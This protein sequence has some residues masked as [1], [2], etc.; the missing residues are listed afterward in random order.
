[1]WASIDMKFFGKM[2]TGAEPLMRN[3]SLSGRLTTFASLA[4]L[5]AGVAVAVVACSSTE[6]RSG[7]EPEPKPEAGIEAGNPFTPGKVPCS[8]LACKRPT[9]DRPGFSVQAVNPDGLEDG[10]KCPSTNG[11]DCKSGVCDDKKV[12]APRSSA[13]TTITGK[14]Y[15]PAGANALYNVM[16]YIPGGPNGDAELPVI[17]EGVSCETCASVAL[18]PM[19]VAL[20]NTKGE[21]ELVDVPVDKE[22]PIVVQVGKWRRKF[23]VPVT[24]GCEENKIPDHDFR[25]P[26]NGKEGDMPNIAV[27][28]GGCD[29]LACLLRGIGIDESE[30]VAGDSAPGHVHVFNGDVSTSGK[31]PGAPNAGGDTVNPF[32]GQLWNDV[33]KLSKYDMVM[34][35]CECDEH[36]ENKGG[37]V[38]RPGARQAMWEYANAG[39]KI[40]GTHYHYTWFKNS[41]QQDWQQIASWGNGG[42]GFGDIYDVDQTFPKGASLADWLVNVNASSTKGQIQ[43]TGVTNALSSVKP[44]AQSWVKKGSDGVRYF[45]VNTPIAAPVAEQCGR[46]VYGDLHLMG[47]GSSAAFP[48]GCPASGGLAA[49]Q[50]AL[51]F[52]FFDLAGCVQADN[53]PPVLPH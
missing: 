37:D 48:S 21:F 50:K 2:N 41:P 9:C 25:L 45:S 31:F 1:M 14:V 44:P 34:M 49:Q 30:F 47:N 52:M 19:V 46:A 15:D 51:E 32:G 7:F 27:T 35:S 17:T 29:A 6:K 26:K 8:G 4:L 20:T 24:K 33:A 28:T 22:I 13:T 42:G 3:T 36:N 12:C 16:V 23:K 39:G 43:L 40:F 11:H 18:D 10:A 5:A 53:T 38:G